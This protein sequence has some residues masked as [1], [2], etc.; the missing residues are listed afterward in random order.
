MVQRLCFDERTRIN[1]MREA[2]LSVAVIAER[3]GRDRSTVYQELPRGGGLNGYCAVAAHQRTGA[4]AVRPKNFKL[5]GNSV[6]AGTVA[7]RLSR[8]WSPHAASA[9]L[10]GSGFRVCAE[11]IYR[12]C[13]A[14]HINSGLKAGSWKSLPCGH[15]RRKHHS[16]CETAKRSVLGDYKPL[17]LRSKRGEERSEVGHW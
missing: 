16:R 3:L 12:A 5:A 9:D 14:N 17:T 13:Y 11:T 1:A 4:K 7:A 6:L 2:Q 8:K 10:A 15:R